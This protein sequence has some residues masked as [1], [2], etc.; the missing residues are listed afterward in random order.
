MVLLKGD[1]S[2]M[3]VVESEH[4]ARGSVRADRVVMLDEFDAPL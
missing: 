1:S 2:R 4:G 3:M